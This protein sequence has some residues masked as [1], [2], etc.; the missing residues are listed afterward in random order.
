MVN[1]SVSSYWINKNE[2]AENAK[3]HNDMMEN[4]FESHIKISAKRT[5]TYDIYFAGN[6]KTYDTIPNIIIDDLDSVGAVIKYQCDK[7]AVLNFASYKNPG[8]RF[9][10]GSSAQEESLCHESFLY[11]VL[12]KFNNG[13]YAWNNL[14]KNKAL[15]LN[16]GLYTPDICFIRNGQMTLADVIT[17][18]APNKTAAKKY[19]KVSDDENYKFLKSRIKF[20]LDIAKDNEV[21]TLILGAFGCGV[22]GQDAT[23]VAEIFKEY[24]ESGMYG[25]ET[26]VFAIPNG[27]VGNLQKFKTVFNK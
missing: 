13:F 19:M 5:I 18:A 27:N 1:K 22:F 25:F 17:C 6:D 23:E 3:K 4:M 24:L 20:V 8:G 7:I 21:K 16:R 15:Y 2:R 14:N 12:V 10:D 9:L 26:V 11:N